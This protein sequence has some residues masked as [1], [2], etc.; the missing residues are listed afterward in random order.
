MTRR[1]QTAI[2]IRGRWF[3]SMRAAAEHF[4]LD[5]STVR[6]AVRTGR[7]DGIGLRGPYRS[8][9]V[10]VRGRSYRSA[11]AAAAAA[12]LGLHVDTVRRALD[13]GR[14]D[15]VGLVRVQPERGKPVRFGGRLWPS[16]AALARAAG[17]SRGIVDRAVGAGNATALTR[18]MV[19]LMAGDA[20][21]A[22]SRRA[23]A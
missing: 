13:D 3:A 23:A 8:L 10:R 4:G 18:L 14:E 22:A 15:C 6:R 12:S 7:V 9:P 20:A 11:A 2:V 21:A 5:E 1:G 19:A 17:V 16:R